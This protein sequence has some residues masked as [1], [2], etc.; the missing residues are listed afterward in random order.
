M[1][2]FLKRRKSQP[3]GG[4]QRCQEC[5]AVGEHMK[6]CPA[7]KAEAAPVP[8]GESAQSSAHASQ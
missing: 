8:K 4:K 2:N 7:R 6:W 5:G 1:L 3:A